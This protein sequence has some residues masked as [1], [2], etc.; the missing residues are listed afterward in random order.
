M[1]QRPVHIAA[2]KWFTTLDGSINDSVT[3]LDLADASDLPTIS[4]FRDTVIHIDSEKMRVTA[5][6]SN[7]LTVERGYGGSTAAS[8]IDGAYAAMF[9]VR[10]F[11]N[12]MAERI[13]T[14]EAHL[15]AFFTVAEG[16][17]QDGGLQVEAEGTPSM[18]V[19]VSA[20]LAIVSGQPVA[21]N[22]VTS[23]VFVA[24]VTNPRIDIVQISQFGVVTSK[25]GTEAGSPSAPAVD[26][27]NLLLANIHHT[28]AE[29][30]IKDT[31]DSTNGYIEPAQVYL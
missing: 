23:L 24:P 2:D 14:L 20:G 31:D 10:E 22:A 25:A 12:D 30:V 8:H 21:A 3:S 19:T 4:A 5:V 7:T 6:S 18:T 28:T 11:F 27:G 13:G 15:G 9:H 16:V 17:R 1:A 26:T 29:T